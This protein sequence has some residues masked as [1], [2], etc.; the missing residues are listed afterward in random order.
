MKLFFVVFRLFVLLPN[1]MNKS[2]NNQCTYKLIIKS[3]AAYVYANEQLLCLFQC[4]SPQFSLFSSEITLK[5]LL[6]KGEV[7]LGE[8]SPQLHLGEYSPMFTL[9]PANNCLT[10]LLQ[11][12]LY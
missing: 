9:P 5:Q 12:N 11:W 7:N 8:Y 1:L 2:I 6:A 10:V 4:F 3:M